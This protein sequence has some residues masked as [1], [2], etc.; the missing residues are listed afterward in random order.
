MLLEVGTEKPRRLCVRD[1]SQEVLSCRVAYST[2]SGPGG[3]INGFLVVERM[4][5]PDHTLEKLSFSRVWQSS[6]DDAKPIQK[7]L[8][9]R[10]VVG[11]GRFYTPLPLEYHAG[12]TL[13]RMAINSKQINVH[14]LRW[15]AIEQISQLDFFSL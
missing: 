5:G 2:S 8:I 9:Q 12:L 7:G 11:T 4:D 6:E 3:D 13:S 1:F 10:R 14:P 15:P